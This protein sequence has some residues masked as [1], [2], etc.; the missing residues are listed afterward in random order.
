MHS[1]QMLSEVF[2]PGKLFKALVTC[3]QFDFDLF[4]RLLAFFGL[5]AGGAFQGLGQ[6]LVQAV[7]RVRL[8]QLGVFVDHMPF[9][10]ALGRGSIFAEIAGK[11]SLLFVDVG[12]V[13]LHVGLLHGPEGTLLALENRLSKVISIDVNLKLSWKLAYVIIGGRGNGFTL[14]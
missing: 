3:F 14:S 11:I 13:P 4:L 2:F 1:E 6:V 5:D 10:Y 7:D 12:H 8:A 9:Q